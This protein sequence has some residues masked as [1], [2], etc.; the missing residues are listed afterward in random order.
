MAITSVKLL[1]GDSSLKFK[2]NNMYCGYIKSIEE[3]NITVDCLKLTKTPYAVYLV[4]HDDKD[5]KFGVMATIKNYYRDSEG[6]EEVDE[7]DD[8]E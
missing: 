2:P 7:E 4:E 3:V 1:Q 5:L 6:I 8:E